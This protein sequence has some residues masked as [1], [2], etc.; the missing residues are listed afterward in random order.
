L[1]R[2]SPGF[3]IAAITI[4]GLGIGVNT[5]LFSLINA[6][7]INPLPY[8]HAEK[9]LQIFQAQ[10]DDLGFGIS[11]PGFVDMKN[12]QHSMEDLA[13][14]SWDFLDLSGGEIPERATAIFANA[15][16]F[17]LTGVPFVLGRPFSEDE[18]VPNGPQVI[19]LGDE[20]WKNRF[21]S[22]PNIVGKTIRLSDQSFQVV[23][24]CR[25]QVQDLAAPGKGFVYLPLRQ[26]EHHG[27][28]FADRTSAPF[29]L[30]GRL[31]KDVAFTEARND[32]EL[33]QRNLATQYPDTEGARTMR[34]FTFLEITTGSYSKTVWLI[35]IA[36][37][38]LLLIACI[39]VAN[40]LFAKAMDRQGEIAIRVAIGASRWRI[41]EQSLIETLFLSLVGGGVGILIAF[42]V[43]KLTK[44]LSAEY[45]ETFQKVPVDIS[46]LSFVVGTIII[47]ALVA[48]LPP[49]W[50][51]SNVDAASGMKEEG[52]NR[53]IGSRWQGARAFLVVAQV[54]L[55]CSLIGAA[56]LL[57]R[58]YQTMMNIDL[59]FNP[60]EVLTGFVYPTTAKY[61][62]DT[63]RE[64][65]FFHDVL[66]R[67]RSLP[68]VVDAA[69]NQDQP[70]ESTVGGLNVEFHVAGTPVAKKA[71]SPLWIFRRFRRSTFGLL[72]F[73]YFQ[74]G[75]SP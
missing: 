63:S 50:S 14:V 25:K 26:L 11:Y 22:D 68:G 33:I 53:T 16:L 42:L 29:S 73:L 65:A 70:F 17:K 31:K 40:L 74:G 13:L 34:V 18:D 43:L 48:G 47:V 69:L 56:A 64:R 66:E 54:A 44:A 3:A 71:K 1:L 49:A 7:I 45:I 28:N 2:K 32:L 41:M 46:A 62:T 8:P 10:G 55:A 58:T 6:V 15:A 12:S 19:V 36:G 5:A 23:G 39:N 60:H 24:V 4:L 61:T 52:G 59:G 20:L 75:I 67:A 21:N 51:A 38:C 72:G 37:L 35:G 27:W 57:T 9:I 30:F